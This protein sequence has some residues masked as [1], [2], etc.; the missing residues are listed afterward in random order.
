MGK[1]LSGLFFILSLVVSGQVP[2]TDLWLF[3]IETDK[4]KQTVLKNPL[5]ITNREGYDNQPSFSGDGKRIYYVSI[6]EDKQAD[7]YYYEITNKTTLPF[8]KT[9]LSEYSPT[10]TDNGGFIASVVVEADSAQRIHFINTVSGIDD[11][12]L[13]MDSV[14]YFTFLNTDTVIYYKLT[15]PHSLRYYVTSTNEDKWLGNAPIRTFKALNR[16]TFIYGLKDST[17]VHFYKYDFLLRKASRYASYPSANEDIVWHPL[18]GLV[19]SEETKLLRYD[20][21]KGQWVLLFDLASFQIKKITRFAF[22][23]KTKYLVVVNNL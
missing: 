4:L 23:P 17:Q 1:K 15:D 9:K 12:K 11:N 22:D 10:L 2:N 6:K 8:T 21:S 5:N 19:K 16:H 7:I 20:E 13:E 14:G 3:K 18:W